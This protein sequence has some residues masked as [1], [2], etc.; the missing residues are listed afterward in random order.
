[1]MGEAEEKPA[2][3]LPEHLLV[4]TGIPDSFGTAEAIESYFCQFGDISQII[5]DGGGIAH[6]VFAYREDAW[7]ALG[8]THYIDGC[9]V[10]VS[11]ANGHGQGDGGSGAEDEGSVGDRL[12]A[13][14]A[15]EH[16]VPS[17]VAVEDDGQ[18]ESG[19]VGSHGPADENEE[20][21]DEAIEHRP[22]PANRQD[23]DR[24]HNVEP[25]KIFVADL[26][27]TTSDDEVFE[28][29]M[30]YGAVVGV[31]LKR[32]DAGQLRGFGFVS[33][34]EA[35]SV[36]AVLRDYSK[37]CLQ[38]RH[39]ECS[40]YGT[41]G[42]AC[43]GPVDKEQVF[44]SG[45]P[46]S[47][48]QQALEEHFSQ[49]GEVTR[50][51]RAPGKHFA[52]VRFSSGSGAQLALHAQE[53]HVIDG[54]W[55]AVRPAL[56]SPGR[57]E[58]RGEAG[59]SWSGSH[60][61]T[62]REAEAGAG[63]KSWNS[64]EYGARRA[65][66]W[67]PWRKNGPY[68]APM[69]ANGHA[70]ASSAKPWVKVQDWS[71]T[72]R[73]TGGDT[74]PTV[75]RKRVFVGGL[76]ST[77]TE[78]EVCDYFQQYGRVATLT[79][80]HCF[81]YVKFESEESVKSVLKYYYVHKL[82]E[83]WIEC[84]ACGHFGLPRAALIKDR[85]FVGGLQRDMTDTALELHFSKY[86][87]IKE[88]SFKKDRGFAFITFTSYA[89]VQLALH[90]FELHTIRGKWVQV[91]PVLDTSQE[92]SLDRGSSVAKSSDPGSSRAGHSG[93]LLHGLPTPPAPAV[94]THSK[95]A[96]TPIGIRSGDG[97]GSKAWVAVRPPEPGSGK[98]GGKSRSDSAWGSKGWD[99]ATWSSK[100][101][102][103]AGWSSQEWKRNDSQ[104]WAASSWSSQGSHGG[105]SK[106]GAERSGGM[107]RPMVDT[108]TVYVSG[109]PWTV[110][111]EEV[112]KYFEDY[113]TVVG[114]RLK[115]DDSGNAKGF[116]F[117]TFSSA[118]Q[119]KFVLKDYDRH[120]MHGKW[121][122][123]MACG[124]FGLAQT[125]GPKPV[126]AKDRVFVGGLP[127]SASS[128]ALESHF[129]EFG[130]VLKAEVRREKGFGF[131]TFGSGADVQL[132]LHAYNNH[133]ID[134]KWVEV[135]PVIIPP[136]SD[137]V[138]SGG[139]AWVARS[140]GGHAEAWGASKNWSGGTDSRNSRHD[141][142]SW[143]SKPY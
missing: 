133:I 128:E 123:C 108:E 78:Q 4:V 59:G 24:G 100:S 91:K 98:G 140:T 77:V 70:G 68:D 86:G 97:G 75:D 63:W 25:K 22:R 15:P 48:T 105:D 58:A 126:M 73:P 11:L 117:V 33:F 132:A 138:G 37:H 127:S 38:G 16:D 20:A 71:S 107:D 41:F 116:G 26:P 87:T 46:P 7:L 56:T 96:G 92:G 90:D 76:P 142:G 3:D 52:F 121:F 45:L 32:D 61:S 36:K 131:V 53:S 99:V 2:D 64:S 18:S 112:G 74:K 40:A 125:S 81:C 31:S 129:S 106:A 1:M 51:H 49:F 88:I 34:E 102:A 17:S 124:K 55:L 39:F 103:D 65:E 109:L 12:P 13:S 115:R 120:K 8:E 114:L 83:K 42:G 93:S 57:S 85:I 14:P 30:G 19:W 101:R 66:A 104:G 79:M 94:V 139:G 80:R 111:D 21:G 60:W 35:D 143:R 110:T 118:K 69:S 130:R 9:L 136:K 10:E 141:H 44:I 119:V 137:D 82:G 27:R 6:V 84:Q 62:G 72:G 95:P 5:M 29:F 135:K 43:S 23:H 28:Y 67:S 54:R 89:S 134:G 47:V 113:G 122:E 50:V